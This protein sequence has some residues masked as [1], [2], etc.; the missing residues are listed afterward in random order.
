[1]P[2]AKVSSSERVHAPSIDN[3]AVLSQRPSQKSTSKSTSSSQRS[4]PSLSQTAAPRPSQAEFPPLPGNDL[5]A[6]FSAAAAS[7]S[8]APRSYAD[9]AVELEELRLVSIPNIIAAT[10]GLRLGA[11]VPQLPKKNAHLYPVECFVSQTKYDFT[12]LNLIMHGSM[13]PLNCSCCKAP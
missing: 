10:V 8:A 3:N 12:S 11:R 4:A 1:M 6:V 13:R 7:A 2:S 5:P 9:A